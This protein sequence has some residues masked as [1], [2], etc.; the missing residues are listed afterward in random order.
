M[1][2][3]EVLEVVAAPSDDSDWVAGFV[4]GAGIVTEAALI[5]FIIVC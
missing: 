5:T 4:I 2:D 3:M 1:L